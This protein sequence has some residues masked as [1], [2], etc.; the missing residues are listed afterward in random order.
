MSTILHITKRTHWDKALEAGRLEAETAGAKGFIHC[1]MPHQLVR[2][3]NSLF[4]GQNDLVLLA[5]DTDR[6]ASEIRFENRQGGSELFPHIHGPLNLD[7]VRC[8]YEFRPAG[9]G[10][11]VLPQGLA[12]DCR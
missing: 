12:A 2:V 4:R 11:F 8:V 3:A 10:T 7:A 5:I 1:S 6:V 9:D